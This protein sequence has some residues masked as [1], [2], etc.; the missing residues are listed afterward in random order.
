M[1]SHSWDSVLAAYRGTPLNNAPLIV[2]SPIPNSFSSLCHCCF[3]G[4]LTNKPT[5]PMFLSQALLSGE[6]TRFS[7]KHSSFYAFPFPKAH[8]Q[9]PWMAP[10]LTPGWLC[11]AWPTWPHR[12]WSPPFLAALS[13][14]SWLPVGLCSRHAIA[15]HALVPSHRLEHPLPSPTVKAQVLFTIL[16]ACPILWKALPDVPSSTGAAAGPRSHSSSTLYGIT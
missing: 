7:L 2:L 15:V 5:P 10:G 4:H 11:L 13:L 3:L 16:L 8:F 12:L 14:T 6:L 1:A 9:S